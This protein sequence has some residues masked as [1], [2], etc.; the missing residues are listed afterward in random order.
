MALGKSAREHDLC[1]RRDNSPD[2]SVVTTWPGG[3]PR[4]AYLEDTK[5]YMK[6]SHK[7][8]EVTRR[9]GHTIEDQPF[10][11]EA[12]QKDEPLIQQPYPSLGDLN[13]IESYHRNAWLIFGT[14]VSE[15]VLPVPDIG[16]PVTS[17]S[18]D[19]I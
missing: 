15:G 12:I 16:N 5:S 13:E 8:K 1:R 18:V 9:K 7:P 6:K 19:Y 3:D 10:G 2:Q 17:R 14:L 4:R 11:A